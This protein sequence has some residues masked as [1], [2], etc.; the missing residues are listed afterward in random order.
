MFNWFINLF[1]LTKKAESIKKSEIVKTAEDANTASKKPQE[2]K[3]YSREELKQKIFNSVSNTLEKLYSELANKGQLFSDIKSSDPKYHAVL[4]TIKNSGKTYYD[5]AYDVLRRVGNINDYNY[6]DIKEAIKELGEFIDLQDIKAIYVYSYI[7]KGFNI[8]KLPDTLEAMNNVY[9]RAITDQSLIKKVKESDPYFQS[10]SDETIQAIIYGE[11]ID[12][13]N[14]LYTRKDKNLATPQERLLN[15]APITQPQRKKI[16]D[17]VDEHISNTIIE[18]IYSIL[19]QGAI[20]ATSTNAHNLQSLRNIAKYLNEARNQKETKQ[21]GAPIDTDNSEENKNN[22]E[23]DIADPTDRPDQYNSLNDTAEHLLYIL[24]AAAKIAGMSPELTRIMYNAYRRNLSNRNDISYTLSQIPLRTQKQLTIPSPRKLASEFFNTLNNS[25]VSIKVKDADD[26]IKMP[27]IVETKSLKDLASEVRSIDFFMNTFA[28]NR[29]NHLNKKIVSNQQLR[30][31]VTYMDRYISALEKYG[32]NNPGNAEEL[33]KNVKNDIESVDT[34]DKSNETSEVKNEF[35]SDIDATLPYQIDNLPKYIEKL[36]SDDTYLFAKKLVGILN[37]VEKKGV[38]A[39]KE[40]LSKRKDLLVS[41][42]NKA[43]LQNKT[44][45]LNKYRESLNNVL[46][47]NIAKINSDTSISSKKRR[48]YVNAASSYFSSLL[49]V[50]SS[51]NENQYKDDGNTYNDHNEELPLVELRK[52]INEY[53]ASLTPDKEDKGN[54]NLGTEL[55]TGKSAKNSSIVNLLIQNINEDLRNA[56]LFVLDF[57]SGKYD[58]QDE[59]EQNKE[60]AKKDTALANKLSYV[61]AAVTKSK[62][63]QYA[64]DSVAEALSTNPYDV[65]KLLDSTDLA[66]RELASYAV[67]YFV[68]I[69]VQLENVYHNFTG[70]SYPYGYHKLTTNDLKKFSDG[71]LDAFNLYMRKPETDL[72]ARIM[73]TKNAKSLDLLK[74]S[75]REKNPT[76]YSKYFSNKSNK[77]D[78]IIFPA[79][80]EGFVVRDGYEWYEYYGRNSS[81]NPIMSEDPVHNVI[82]DPEVYYYP[83]TDKYYITTGNI[84]FSDGAPRVSGELND[85]FTA[86]KNE[87]MPTEAKNKKYY[88]GKYEEVLSKDI[89]SDVERIKEQE[90]NEPEVKRDKREPILKFKKQIESEYN[91]PERLHSKK[92]LLAEIDKKLSDIGPGVSKEEIEKLPNDLESLSEETASIKTKLKSI[93]TNI[94]TYKLLEDSYRKYV[95]AKTELPTANENYT[96]AKDELD[97]VINT[98]YESERDKKMCIYE[99]KMKVIDAK[100]KITDAQFSIKEETEKIQKYS[101]KLGITTKEAFLSYRENI[102]KQKESLESVL[103][104]KEE[105]IKNIRNVLSGKGEDIEHLIYERANVVNDIKELEAMIDME[106]REAAVNNKNM[107]VVGE[108]SGFYFMP[109]NDAF[110]KV[111]FPKK[112]APFFAIH[113]K[114]ESTDNRSLQFNQHYEDVASKLIE[115][116]GIETNYDKEKATKSLSDS[117]KDNKRFS[118]K[119]LAN[120][121]KII[122]DNSEKDFKDVLD[123]VRQSNPKI[124]DE[125]AEYLSYLPVTEWTPEKALRKFN[126]SAVEERNRNYFWS[127]LKESAWPVLIKN[128]K[129]R[130]VIESLKNGEDAD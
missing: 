118:T 36:Q 79:F 121:L 45:L 119:I 122:H 43:Y 96:K 41:N 114:A 67:K 65:V 32:T 50:L 15:K 18:P 16:K 10:L 115:N 62:Y 74:E 58:K 42:Y 6:K 59:S 2:D 53:E 108:Y 39:V 103:K 5:L 55:T 107:E 76:L 17:I 87:H 94:D 128:D 1:S 11:D 31:Y 54:L 78:T 127:G 40:E 81:G 71:D 30:N 93:K 117:K 123:I 12:T 63:P 126:E 69:N 129:V 112:A 86:L 57:L 110:I 72:L 33:E 91:L 35:I 89:S 34:G 52:K 24:P 80:P 27:D 8:N 120:V 49:G 38:P 99:A 70:L 100:S 102:N 47:D 60:T 7:L 9:K 104:S 3:I 48:G 29:R 37:S 14:K 125:L 19:L 56:Y 20:K 113:I 98:A 66:I 105:S 111:A 83:K 97:S 75:L 13:Q 61:S 28:G 109:K 85:S 44:Q 106:Q 101:E 51:A 116:P 95:A 73:N 26:S 21:V 124:G 46:R 92:N 22:A 84:A 23:E 68:H 64:K 25:T 82:I 90:P 130:K 77:P 4:E 88:L